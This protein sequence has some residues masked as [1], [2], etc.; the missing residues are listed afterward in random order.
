[1]ARRLR[2][3]PNRPV[4]HVTSFAL[5]GLSMSSI[6]RL[7]FVSVLASLALA[8]PTSAEE[9]PLKQIPAD[10][11]IIIHIRGAERV[12]GQFFNLLKNAL[13]KEVAEPATNGIEELLKEGLNGREL[14]GLPADGPIFIVNPGLPAPG[15]D[16]G[17]A[18]I[19]RAN[20]YN[21]F[22]DGLLKG[23]ERKT[24]KKDPA[25]YETATLGS[26]DFF[27]IQRPNFAI[28][29]PTKE[30]A[31]QFTKP[32]AGIDSKFTADSAKRFLSADL[33][34][35]VD[36]AAVNKT[37]GPE[38]KEV[39]TLIEQALGQVTHLYA[40]DKNTIESIKGIT[41]L[42]FQAIEDSRSV[43]IHLNFRP[44]GVSLQAE[45]LF[46]KETRT[47][48]LLKS[49]R[50]APLGDIVKLPSGQMIYMGLHV[51]P[52]LLNRFP[53]ALFGSSSSPVKDRNQRIQV[54][55][56]RMAD[57]KPRARFTSAVMPLEGMQI[58]EYEDPAEALDA[59]LILAESLEAGDTF[60]GIILK[61]RPEIKAHHVKYRDL[62][63]D[64]VRTTWDIDKLMKAALTGQTL[65]PDM[66][67][68][69][70][71]QMLDLMKKIAGDGRKMWIGVSGKNLIQV[72]AKDWPS[73][74]RQIDQFLDDKAAIGKDT[75]FQAARRELPD[76]T[77]ALI[78]IEAGSYAGFLSELMSI[79][80]KPMPETKSTQSN[81]PITTERP[82]SYLG[83]AV[84]VQPERCVLDLWI[85][86][87]AIGAFYKVFDPLFKM[88]NGAVPSPTV[89]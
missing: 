14:R 10:T 28:V 5:E 46:A 71:Q 78:L 51:E 2:T 6:R 79:I 68:A 62:N 74:Q 56:K 69:T 40:Y 54:Q 25:G 83:V 16:T 12:K 44:E 21:E 70:R 81:I 22:R 7:T 66:I 31:D 18:F 63:L 24:L 38:I 9:S 59:Y 19:L 36:M 61:E 1:M 26:T 3:P 67:E 80:A 13:P 55:I 27:F 58:W 49:F 64:Y 41:D 33:S 37:F 42:L 86:A 48:A 72:T 23:D 15:Q 84:T 34:L 73:A 85:P 76:K 88:A 39:R 75:A 60:E 17:A 11:Q 43:A 8:T 30:L 47:G 89:P 4:A 45:T 50:P 20:N 65:P 53:E 82:T 29:T 32:Q 35:Y 87:P 77:S 57:A 52:A